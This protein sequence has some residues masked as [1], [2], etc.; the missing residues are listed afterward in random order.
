M[1]IPVTIPRLGWNMEEGVFLGWLKKDGD[2]VRPGEAL[3]RLESDKATEEIECHDSGILRIPESGPKDGD[4]VLV[5]VVIGQLVQPGENF[6]FTTPLTFSRDAV[7]ERG[8]DVP[9]SATASRLN[10]SDTSEVVA[11]PRARRVAAELGIDWTRLPGTGRSG[12]IR[13]RDVRA[14]EQG[15]VRGKPTPVSA[16]R[17]RTA[18][19]L[20]RSKEATVPV[21]LTTTAD[22]TRLVGMRRE[23]LARGLT[24]SLTDCFV[25]LTAQALEQHRLLAARWEGDHLMVPDEIH[26]GIAVD[27][28]AGLL[29]PVLHHPAKSSLEELAAQSRTLV[30]RARQGKLTTAD[31]Q[32]GV[33]TITNLGMFGIDA[34]T[35]VIN[36]PECA[37]LGVG[38]VRRVPAFVEDRVEPRDEV[39]LSLTFDHRVV[40]GAPAA[41]FLQTLVKGIENPEECHAV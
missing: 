20:L 10:V 9:R 31:L 14:A 3:F 17:A 19:R 2:T 40:D 24:A 39:T 1:A 12:R 23:W 8:V 32:G 16:L 13:E 38:R 35:P 30:E 36:H 7:A 18:Q 11:S 26:I 34:F 22:V 41:R 4:K 15:R 21:T 37:I 29:V 25:K 28:D 33:F 6:T 5:G 27:T